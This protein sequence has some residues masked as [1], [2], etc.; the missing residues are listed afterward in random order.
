MQNNEHLICCILPNNF[1]HEQG[2]VGVLT[3]VYSDGTIS[4]SGAA[5]LVLCGKGTRVSAAEIV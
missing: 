3:E 1:L 4:A 5:A 2:D